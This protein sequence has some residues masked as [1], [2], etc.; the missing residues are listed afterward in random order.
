MIIEVLVGA[1]A[2]FVGGVLFGRRNAKKVN[3]V[4]TVVEKL[5]GQSPAATT[6]AAPVA[7]VAT[8][9]PVAPVETPAPAAVEPV[10][11]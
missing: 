5:A 2:G 10:K 11:Q 6:H 7:V 3:T 1:V 9:A 8:P 4:V